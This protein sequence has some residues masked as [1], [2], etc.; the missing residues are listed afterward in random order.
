VKVLQLVNDA[1]ELIID[2]LT[3]NKLNLRDTRRLT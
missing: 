2:Q 1:K 3:I